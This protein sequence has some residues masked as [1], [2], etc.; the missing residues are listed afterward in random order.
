MRSFKDQGALGVFTD[1]HDNARFLHFNG[2]WEMLKNVI[3][4]NLGS[5]GVPIFYYGTE[6]GYAGANDPNN[7][8]VLWN[9]LN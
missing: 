2:D 9:N 5:E 7:R 1:N 8:E 3:Q 4:F 6:Q